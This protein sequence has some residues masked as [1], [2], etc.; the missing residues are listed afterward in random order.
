MKKGRFPRQLIQ[1]NW[2]FLVWAQSRVEILQ[3]QSAP[4]HL[5]QCE[6]TTQKMCKTVGVFAPEVAGT[7]SRFPSEMQPPALASRR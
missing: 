2:L 3:Q 7:L 6:K 5:H 4:E 1:D